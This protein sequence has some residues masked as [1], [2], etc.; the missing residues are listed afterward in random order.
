MEI[1]HFTANHLSQGC[2]TD[3]RGTEQRVETGRVNGASQVLEYVVGGAGIL[4]VDV[5]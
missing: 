3:T 4:V 1:I 5:F 2:F